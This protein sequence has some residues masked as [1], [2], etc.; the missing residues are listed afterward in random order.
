MKNAMLILA[1][2]VSGTGLTFTAAFAQVYPSKPI[3]FVVGYAAGGGTDTMARAVASKLPELLGQQVLVENRPGANANL[4]AE[5]VARQPADGHTVLFISVS[6]A[7]SKS[8]YGNLGYDIESDYIPIT[9]VGEVPNLLAVHPSLPVKTVADLVRL[10]RK[11][12][13]PVTF[14]VA[15]VGSPGHFAGEMLNMA[16]GTRLSVIPYKGGGPL[17]TDLMAG[18]V[19]ATFNAMPPLLPLVRSQRVRAIAVS[20]SKRSAALPQVPTVAESGVAGYAVSTWYGCVV[21]TGTSP[22]IVSKL[23][24][25]TLRSIADPKVRD[26]LTNSGTIIL[27]GSSS[28][29]AAFIKSEV[30]KYARIAAKAAIRIQ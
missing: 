30:A 15:G 21:R 22:D 8:V 5:Y 7:M 4:A 11:N 23:H 24:A 27:G 19:M 6:H 13:E 18:H 29:V 16:A 25:A 17:A 26:T 9:L 10:G 28:D 1:I 14:A 2:L 3:R 12:A 20:T